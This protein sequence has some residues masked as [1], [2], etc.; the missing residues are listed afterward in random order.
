MKKLFLLTIIC[1]IAFLDA[2]AQQDPMFTKY[3]FNSLSFNPGYAGSKDFLSIRALYR[4]Q[5][6]GIDGAPT[7]QTVTAHMP[8]LSRVGVGISL[9]HD[10]IGINET[11]NGYLSYAYRI[12]FG[13]GTVALGVQGGVVNYRKDYNLLKYK[14]PRNMDESF[15]GDGINK[16]MP[17]FGAGVYYNSEKFYVGLSSPHL[18]NYDLRDAAGS[19]KWAKSYRH[20][21]V[22]AGAAIP[23]TGKSLI[24][25]PSGLLKIAGF[26]G[27]NAGDPNSLNQVGAPVEVDIDASF[28]FYQTFWIGASFRTAVEAEQFGGESSFDSADIWGAFYLKNGLIIGASY[29]YTL[30]KLQENAKGSFEVML[31]YDFNYQTKKMNTPRYF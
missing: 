11:T 4:D 24:F 28:L 8:I 31:G 15:L 25:K 5:W 20:Y 23:I 10:K 19:T 30:T 14:D 27:D 6:W 21:Y 7:S 1:T 22:T 13:N 9:M 26:L 16:W 3:M 12:P 17:N 2:N 18:I 29:D